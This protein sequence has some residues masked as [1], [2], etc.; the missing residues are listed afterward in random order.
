MC[1]YVCMYIYTHT[2]IKGFRVNPIEYSM[3][4]LAGVALK[5]THTGG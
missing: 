3:A 4:P 1:V 2:Y 5:A